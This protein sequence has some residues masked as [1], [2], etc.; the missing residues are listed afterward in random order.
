MAVQKGDEAPDFTLKGAWGDE[1]RLS[2]LRGHL[3]AMLIF[4]PKDGTSG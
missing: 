2:D 4:Y 1:F 3:R